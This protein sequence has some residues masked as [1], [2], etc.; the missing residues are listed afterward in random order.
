[1]SSSTRSRHVVVF[2]HTKAEQDHVPRADVSPF[3]AFRRVPG[4]H[5]LR[6][7]ERSFDEPKQV[8]F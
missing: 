3:R 4:D 6:Q 2:F 5:L 7:F 1:M 8:G